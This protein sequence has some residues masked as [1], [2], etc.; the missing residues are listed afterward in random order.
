MK[1]EPL[2]K[3]IPKDILNTNDYGASKNL[4][5][6]SRMNEMNSNPNIRKSISSLAQD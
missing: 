3:H 1:H 5:L 6:A 4:L 2:S